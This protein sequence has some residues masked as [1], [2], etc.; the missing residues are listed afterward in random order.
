MD[1][2]RCIFFQVA[3]ANQAAI[4]FWA[5]KISPLGLTAVQG[6]LL[7]F[8]IDMDGVTAREL[9]E[10]TSLDSATLTGI[11]DRLEAMELIERKPD[12]GDRRAKL[13]SL[14]EKGGDIAG[15]ARRLVI[16]SNKEFC[17][18]FTPEEETMFRGLLKRVRER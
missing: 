12:P 3:K 4:R 10:R 9:G 14:T 13:V 1:P 6:M 18:C 11:I 7:N 5:Q 15:Q 16:E 2:D 17:K 8:L